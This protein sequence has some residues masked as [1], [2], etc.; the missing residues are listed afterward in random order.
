MKR[1]NNTVLLAVIACLL[2]ATAYPFIKIGLLYAPP[3]HF[4]GVRFFISGL[5]IL[6]IALRSGGYM[7]MVKENKK[8]V[9]YVTL[10][11]TFFN[12][13][14]FYYGMDMVP[15]A[16]G[17]IIVG[18]QPLVVA[19]VAAIMMKE[20]K[21]SAM[22][23][24]TIVLGIVGVVLVSAGRQTFGFGSHREII[25]VVLIFSANIVTGI[26]NVIV[27][28]KGKNIN[29]HVLSSSTLLMGGLMLFIFSIPFGGW[30][31]GA[32]PLRYWLVL[33]WLAFLS[34][35][36]FSI[37]YVLLKRPGVKVSDLNFWKF[38]IPV[39]GAILSWLMI[40]G[41]NPEWVSVTGMI[42]ITFSIILFYRC[43]SRNGEGC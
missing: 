16:I 27:S 19:I 17:A 34:A 41:E 2:W 3:L 36:S 10:L 43:T 30:P 38:L 5:L 26:S 6:P 32:L 7:K 33:S 37:W 1:E 8:L 40:P 13:I 28:K 20:D 39:F 31:E 29:P 14:F 21:L 24:T 15:G 22:K 35:V 42:I 23:I 11:Q 12:Y 9:L 4:A 18:A 25:G